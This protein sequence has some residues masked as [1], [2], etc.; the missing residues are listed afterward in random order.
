M[1]S[2]REN[3][4]RYHDII[5]FLPQ[6]VFEV[7]NKG[8]LTFINR[9]AFIKTG[10]TRK[11]F[12]G[13][14]N[15]AHL[16]IP[17]D[18]ERLLA[19]FKKLL[20]GQRIP[21]QE[22]LIL[23]KNGSTFPALIYSVP[24]TENKKIVGVRGV[25]IDITTQKENEEQLLYLGTHD[26]LT[27]LFNR[28]FWEDS[29]KKLLSQR[30]FSSHFCVAILDVDGLK[31]INDSLGHNVGDSL[32]KKV[33]IL[34]TKATRDEDIVARIGGDEFAIILQNM[35]T[36]G[37]FNSW[38]KRLQKKITEANTSRSAKQAIKIS[39]GHSIVT[40]PAQ[41]RD[42]IKKADDRM[43]QEKREHKGL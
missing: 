30:K 34:L 17:G 22:Y 26:K 7:D 15:V 19:D 11:D 28:A 16:V 5:T 36:D 2:K 39:I 8:I 20:K 40:K 6:I 21:G 12:E 13:S 35:E 14:I 4:K 10:Y 25:L 18:A 23:K 1:L 43:Y 9:Q 38:K 37:A 31:T 32:L 33:S 42:A 24:I 29:L 27:G 41:L 3:A